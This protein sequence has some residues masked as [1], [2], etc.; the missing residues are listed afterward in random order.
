M[1]GG[2][3]L[4]L[5]HNGGS[6]HFIWSE[7]MP[8][9]SGDYEMFAFDLL[10]YGASAKPGTGYTLNN[11]IDF[12]A[13]FIDEHELAPVNLVGNCMGSSMSLGF[14][15]RYPEK[16]RGIVLINP[17]TEATFL[18]GYMGP[19]LRMRKIVP[20]FARMIYSILRKVRLNNWLAAQ[21]VNFQTGTCGKSRKIHKTPELCACFTSDG[22]MDSLIGVFDDLM[23]FSFLD[24]LEPGRDFPP[25]CTVWGLQNKV[26]SPRA[27]RKLNKTL[28][29]Q[30]EEWLKGCGHLPMLEKPEQVA[31]IIKD[32]LVSCADPG[33]QRTSNDGE[34]LS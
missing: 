27:G 18:A 33:T 10:G 3:P 32:F 25:V 15:L 2:E 7:V 19:L 12:L 13:A 5:L 14:A 6:S 34:V 20:S 8:W 22:Q 31:G 9:L 28:L 16:V 21:V 30:R 1:G 24:H 23:N 4:I 29:P 26:L 11:Y 17:L